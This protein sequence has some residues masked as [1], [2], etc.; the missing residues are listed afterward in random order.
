MNRKNNLERLKNEE[1][2]ICIIGAG[3]SGAGCAIDATLRGFKVALIEKNDF[4]AET[5]SK[6]TKLIHG[7]VRYL[8]QAFKNLDFAQLKQVRHGLEERHTVLKNAPHLAHPLA[9]ITPVFSWFEGMY[10][11]IGLTLYGFF[12]KNDPLPKAKWLNK[13]ETY[14]H[15]P[16]LTSKLH[17]SVMYY[18]GQLDDARYC[19]ALAHSA[20][21]A[22]AAVVNHAEIIGFENGESGKLTTAIIQ[23]KLA[24]NQSIKIKSKLFINCTGPFADSIR[25]MANPAE[26]SRIRPSK[27]VHIILPM[28]YLQ[29]KDAMLIP[30]T[31]DGRVVFVIPFEG[32]VMVGTTDDE[33]QNLDKEPILIEKEIDFLLETLEP[34]LSKMPQKHE[35]KAGFGG[36][37][38]LIAAGDS[39]ATKKLVRDH[40][41]EHDPKSNLLSLLGGKW[42]TY[43]L[44][45]K[46]TID[47]ACQLLNSNANCST[48]NHLLVGAKNYDFDNWKVIQKQYNLSENTSKHLTLKYGSRANKVL[49]LTDNQAVLKELI[50]PNYPFVKAEVVYTVR[51]EMVCKLRDFFARRIRFELMD[52]SAVYDSIDDVAELMADELNWSTTQKQANIDEYK[53][54][55]K[56]F[57]ASAKL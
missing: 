19:L 53:S 7:G 29:S 27:G 20:D 2:D 24:D 57:K 42:T 45:A 26:Q 14:E 52:W 13:K 40:E 46:D 38:P 8:E 12:A 6:S 15:I 48:E 54:L 43:R 10:F 31:K 11:T 49:Q 50:S 21:E 41:V 3:A 30:K 25:L 18:D 17:S 39:K 33:Y 44:M 56:Q 22:G 5:S 16:T 55:I 47:D 4:A 35:I 1:F 32:E 28:A 36:L 23:D 9:L 34:F 51:E 37:R